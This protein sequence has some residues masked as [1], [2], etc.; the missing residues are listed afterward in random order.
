MRNVVVKMT[1]AQLE[2]RGSGRII[3][4]NG[5]PQEPGAA[6]R[7]KHARSGDEPVHAALPTQKDE[8]RLRLPG[9]ATPLG[10]RPP[11]FRSPAQLSCRFVSRFAPRRISSP[12]WVSAVG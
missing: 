7:R 11:S 6:L 2:C 4:Q 12:D 8:R 1:F 3:K 10:L 9:K 5:R